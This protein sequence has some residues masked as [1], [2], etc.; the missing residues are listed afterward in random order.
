MKAKLLKIKDIKASANEGF[1][2]IELL[3]VIGILAILMGIVLIAINPAHQFALSNN[4]ARRN[5]IAQILSAVGQYEAENK[6]ALPPGLSAN[7][8]AKHIQKDAGGLVVDLC[9]V[10]VAGSIGYLPALPSDPSDNSSS[11]IAQWKHGQDITGVV[12]SGTCGT[13]DSGFT[14]AVDAGS[15]V[16][17]AAPW[18]EESAVITVTR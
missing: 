11:D 16:T 9:G 15:R 2:L 1:T 6:G 5:A 12:G 17:I 18:A 3:V 13:Y 14:V 4:T 7:M 8:A 10:L